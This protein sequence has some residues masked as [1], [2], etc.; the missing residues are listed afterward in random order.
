M[1]R[2]YLPGEVWRYQARDE[3]PL[4]RVFI[5]KVD[6]QENGEEIFHV[7]L[8]N[9]A[10]RAPGHGEGML[11]EIG[12]LPVSRACLEASLTD[13]IPYVGQVPDV[14]EGYAQWH[15]AFMSGE[16]G[17]FDIPIAEI[18]GAM[19][20]AMNDDGAGDDGGAG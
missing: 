11:T 1:A 10:I 14:S 6:R 15:A 12:H 7:A 2:I 9:L 20:R 4:S 13:R 17:V 19:E 3:E 16:A 8:D 18:V 5:A